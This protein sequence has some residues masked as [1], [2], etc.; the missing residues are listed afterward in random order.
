MRK[1]AGCSIWG[2]K[3][4]EGY[5]FTCTQPILNFHFICV[6]STALKSHQ[7]IFFSCVLEEIC[8]WTIYVSFRYSQVIMNS[9][10]HDLIPCLNMLLKPGIEPVT[11][12]PSSSR[13]SPF[14][15]SLPL[16]LFQSPK[17]GTP[18]AQKWGEAS[19][20]SK[21]W[22]PITE[23]LTQTQ[24]RRGREGNPFRPSSFL[25]PVCDLGLRHESTHLSQVSDSSQIFWLIFYQKARAGG[26]CIKIGLPR[27]LTNRSLVLANRI[28]R[29]SIR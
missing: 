26:Y 13:S 11:L 16:K 24:S 12:T 3:L 4:G 18:A 14:A 21:V 29:R 9:G 5:S 19:I 25:C 23:Q 7:N 22:E 28:S 27:L 10:E 1:S 2:S 15:S 8:S 6:K 20:H 17:D